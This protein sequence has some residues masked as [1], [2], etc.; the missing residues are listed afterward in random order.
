MLNFREYINKVAHH[1]DE[2]SKYLKL[3]ILETLLIRLEDYLKETLKQ[4][5]RQN[6]VSNLNPH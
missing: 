4:D 5:I 3:N 1:I 6:I 2:T